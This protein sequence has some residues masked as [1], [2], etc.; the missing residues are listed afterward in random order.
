MLFENP[1][2]H[3]IS[4]DMPLDVFIAEQALRINLVE[5]SDEIRELGIQCTECILP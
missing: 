4:K 2:I 1:P 3:W 5:H